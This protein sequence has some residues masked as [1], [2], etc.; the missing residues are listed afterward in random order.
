[1]ENKSNLIAIVSHIT[2]V[3]W[4]IALILNQSNRSEFSS[5]YIR[6]T[7]GLFLIV[8]VGTWIPII[9]WI[10]GPVCLVLLI[11]SLIGAINKKK[12]PTPFI[13]HFFQMIFA[14]L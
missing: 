12:E 4:V 2:I 1:M 13:G 8:A 10:V 7:L 6:Q 3:G 14:G 9:K 11:V 5:F